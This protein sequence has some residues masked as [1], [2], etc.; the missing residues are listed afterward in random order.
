MTMNQ[1]TSQFQIISKAYLLYSKLA[2]ERG[3]SQTALT[4][5]K[6]SV[7]LLRRAWTN[8]ERLCRIDMAEAASQLSVEKST[9]DTSLNA[10]TADLS[11]GIVNENTTSCGAGFWA[12]ITPLFRGLTHLS[13]LYAHNGMF[14]ET[15]YYAEQALQ[16]V[17]QVKSGLNSAMASA[18]LGSWW[19]KAGVLDKG[20]DYLMRAKAIFPM[21]DKTREAAHLYYYLGKMHGLLGDHDAESVAFKEASASLKAL[22][23][24]TYI[25]HIGHPA[26]Q[27]HGTE[28]QSAHLLEEEMSKLT[29][30]NKK[31]VAPR[32]TSARSKGP[33][34]K[35]AVAPAKVSVDTIT[36]TSKPCPQLTSLQ[37]SLLRQK[38]RGL[39]DTK[40]FDDAQN[41]LQEATEYSASQTDTIDQG[42]LMA[43][44]LILQ[45][46]EHMDADPV[47]S[48][49]QESTISFPSV[50]ASQRSVSE[51]K[52][53]TEKL[54][55]SR[56]SPART[57]QTTRSGRSAARSKSPAP[58]TF[59]DKLRQA[60]EH[61][62]EV[63]ALAVLV[64]QVHVVHTVA[65][66]QN[67]VAILLSAAGQVNGKSLAH[68]GYAS[69]SIGMC[70]GAFYLKFC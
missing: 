31:V 34:K 48:T 27:T 57:L 68:P 61:L 47:Y 67:S 43:K 23:E 15:V 28:K 64:A 24:A 39:L 50:V 65:A 9:I 52:S 54:S 33:V 60:Q 40:S 14:L 17:S 66:L 12:L 38:V 25:N 7:R 30:T 2:L 16:L 20:S 36:P 10:S 22:M 5:A 44:N 51:L 3:A 35:K 58:N 53:G 8:T 55:G 6:L 49:L 69:C 19:L 62:N 37:G 45:S 1:K 41:L 32:K 46:I 56:V 4:Q 13:E 59:F 11:V 29:I 42:L 70:L 63:H 18:A 21:V 26:S